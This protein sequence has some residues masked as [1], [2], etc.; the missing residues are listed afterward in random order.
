MAYRSL[1]VDRVLTVAWRKPEHE[2]LVAIVGE[3]RREHERRKRPL[4][5]LSVIGPAA[6]P[7]GAVRD[8]LVKFYEDV[9]SVCESMHIVIEGNEFQSSIKR[10]V[11]A[12][13]LLVLHGA[14]GRV[15]IENTLEGVRAISP[16]SLRPELA[17][18]QRVAGTMYEF[19]RDVERP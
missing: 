11:I 10:S 16:P 15:F 6:L 7:Q 9:L 2:D 19:A 18:A 13:V 8:E 3:L 14:R 5:Y 12:N 1:L 17:E 4:L